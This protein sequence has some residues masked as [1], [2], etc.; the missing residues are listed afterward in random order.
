MV[1]RFAKTGSILAA[2]S[3]LIPKVNSIDIKYCNSIPLS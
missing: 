3:A 2:S 1:I